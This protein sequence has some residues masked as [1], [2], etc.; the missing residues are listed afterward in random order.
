MPPRAQSLLIG[1]LICAGL[2]LAATAWLLVA[3]A[4]AGGGPAGNT[5]LE[6]V[7]Y[8]RAQAHLPA[9]RDNPQ[10]TQGCRNH[11]RYTV[12][13]LVVGHYEDPSN[14]W[15]TPTGNACAAAG[16]VAIQWA[17]GRLWPINM[18]MSGP[19]HAVGILDPHLARSAYGFYREPGSRLSGAT[20]DVIRGWGQIPSSVDF[21][22]VWPA[23]GESTSLRLYDGTEFPDPLTSCPGY[24]A[25]S[26]LPIILQL[27]TGSVTPH[28]TN[29]SFVRWPY[30]LR[31]CII[32][33]TTYANPDAAVKQLGRSV[34]G[35][36]DA[37]VLIPRRPLQYGATY[38][39]SLRINGQ[40]YS[41]SFTVDN[42]F[43][44]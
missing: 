8:Y 4:Q 38:D 33:E 30:Q 26:G 29:H 24:R 19:F 37:V 41:W 17:T 13:N 39:V 31:H 35:A 32:T 5:W 43:A 3:S 21:P 1:A 23:D 22:I 16:N 6:R 15:Y 40:T 2:G 36:R 7:N 18:W 44:L 11:A 42:P 14:P 20:L 10:W 9:V 27:G 28:V 34:L 12:E 25:P